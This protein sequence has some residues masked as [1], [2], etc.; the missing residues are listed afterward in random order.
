MTKIL[1]LAAA[2]MLLA[3]SSALASKSEDA[4]RYTN[5]LKSSKDPKVRT[6]AAE[7][8]GKL[9]QIRKTYGKDAI[10]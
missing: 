8:I 2:G 6:I 1:T 10:P 3:V 4:A 7:E 9:A 5:D